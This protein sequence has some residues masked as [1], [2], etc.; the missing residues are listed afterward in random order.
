MSE[1]PISGAGI[2][3]DRLLGLPVQLKGSGPV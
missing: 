1:T 3:V 2:S